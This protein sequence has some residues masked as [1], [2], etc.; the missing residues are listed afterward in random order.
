MYSLL[1]RFTRVIH[2]PG[3]M[4]RSMVRLSNL[5]ITAKFRDLESNKVERIIRPNKS[6][7]QHLDGGGQGFNK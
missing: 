4:V 3:S 2:I 1:V 5:A 6:L 7:A